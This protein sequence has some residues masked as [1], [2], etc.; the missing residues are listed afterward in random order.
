[1]S[2]ITAVLRS[3]AE[4]ETSDDEL[5]T[6]VYEELRTMAKI[7]MANER[8]GHTLQATALVHEAWMRI[9]DQQFENR[10]HF[11]SAASEAMRRILVDC[12]RRKKAARRGGGMQRVEFGEIDGLVWE[13]SDDELLAVHDVLERLEAEDPRKAELVKLR[14]FI[15]MTG[16][17]VAEALGLSL[18]TVNRDWAYARAWMYNEIN[19]D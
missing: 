4:N 16:E 1:M 9:G 14:Y 2:K 19:R 5:M 10:R 15:G 3:R 7:R 6:A 11:F 18:A 8:A 13:Q 12:A 17:E